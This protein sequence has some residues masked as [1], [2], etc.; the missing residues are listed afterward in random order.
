MEELAPDG[1]P[2]ILVESREALRAW[3]AVNHVR[4]KGIWVVTYKKATGK[5]RPEYSDIAEEALCFGWIDATANTL[6][7]ER[8]MLWLAPR[9][10]KSGWSRINKDRIERLSALGQMREPGIAVVERAKTNGTWNALDEIEA[11]VIP[12]DLLAAFGRYAGSAEQWESFS[13]SSRRAIL[14]WIRQAKRPET[15]ATRVEESARLAAVGEKAYP[16]AKK[17]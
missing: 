5:P 16:P 17:A 10:P 12:D 11:G 4:P 1:R 6:D 9:N 14:D 13:K 7:D 8:A 15:R 2:M 3:L